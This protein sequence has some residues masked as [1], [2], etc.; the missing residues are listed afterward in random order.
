MIYIQLNAIVMQYTQTAGSTQR[1]TYATACQSD[2][3]EASTWEETPKV[4]SQRVCLRVNPQLMS[5]C[6]SR[7]RQAQVQRLDVYRLDWQSIRL[8]VQSVPHG[9]HER[10]QSLV[11]Q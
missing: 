9:E 7:I 3:D 5:V 6:I 11:I 1:R 8:K 4:R 2:E 10:P